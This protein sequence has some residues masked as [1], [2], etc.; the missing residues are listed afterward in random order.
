MQTI[1]INHWAQAV[2]FSILPTP[3]SALPLFNSITPDGCHLLRSTHR[4]GYQIPRSIP[5]WENLYFWVTLVPFTQFLLK[6]QSFIVSDIWVI[7]SVCGLFF[8]WLQGSI[9]KGWYQSVCSCCGKAWGLFPQCCQVVRCCLFS[10]C[11]K[12]CSSLSLHFLFSFCC[13]SAFVIFFLLDF[14]IFV[15]I[16]FYLSSFPGKAQGVRFSTVSAPAEA[17]P[18]K[19]VCIFFNLTFCCLSVIFFLKN[20]FL[21]WKCINNLV[22]NR[23][24]CCWWETNGKT[25]C[26]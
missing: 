2:A 17:A 22:I 1:N 13:N 16:K 12:V 23:E 5:F 4:R 3:H 25:F 8:V 19:A 10:T 14:A 26:K 15:N 20:R 18:A 9:D 6:I 24:F 11:L 7:E 21:Y